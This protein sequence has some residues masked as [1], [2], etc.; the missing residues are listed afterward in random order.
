MT[1]A[2]LAC[3]LLLS[4]CAAPSGTLT[5]CEQF[6]LPTEAQRLVDWA[7]AQGFEVV[8][9]VS[10]GGK[11]YNVCM[12]IPEITI[13]PYDETCDELIGRPR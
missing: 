5:R 1:K 13:V 3:V 10:G 11:R 4:G 9:T 2:L 12:T 8:T 6:A 7:R